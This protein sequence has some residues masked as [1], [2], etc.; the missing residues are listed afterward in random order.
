MT[1]QKIMSKTNIEE[2]QT[3]I[4]IIFR[5]KDFLHRAFIH[6]SY[7]N[8]SSTESESNERLEFLGDAVL[9][10]IISENLFL[11]F[12]SEDEGHLTTLR[13]RLVNTTSL[14]GTAKELSL[15]ELLYLS[16]G[17]EAS[18]GRQNRS[19]LANTVEALIGAIFLDQGIDAAKTFIETFII[20]KLADIVKSP[21][22]DPK[23]L[24]QEF[25]Q[26]NGFPAPTYKLIEALGPD[27]AKEFTVE[28][29]VDRK[30]YAQGSGR[31]LQIATQNAAAEALKRWGEKKA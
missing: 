18:G 28:V 10:F 23:S 20:K 6:R 21:L 16:R 15:G 27:H 17:E 12:T 2:L 11:H 22:K 19:L 13:S 7:L 4:G 25:A 26:A 14:A 31:S 24:I 3:K 5:N 29:L 8:E 9:E 1:L 30:P